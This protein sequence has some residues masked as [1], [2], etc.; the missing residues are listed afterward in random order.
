VSPQ[1]AFAGTKSDASAK[2]IKAIDGMMIKLGSTS[3]R[4]SAAINSIYRSHLDLLVLEEYSAIEGALGTGGLVALPEDPLRFNLRVRVEGPAPIGEKDL[5]NQA[6]YIA[7]R[8]AALGALFDVASR[9]T[10]GPVEVTSL[11]R[12]SEYQHEL[13]KT[14]SNARTSVPTHTMGLAFDIA[15][16][17]TPLRTVYEIRDV[18]ARMQAAGDILVIG[19]RKQLVFHV[20]PHPSRLGYFAEVYARAVNAGLTGASVVP[21]AP[22]AHDTGP[23]RP[24]V[25]ADIVAV[26]PTADYVEEWWAADGA[27]SDMVVSVSPPGALSSTP[28]ASFF[29]RFASRFATVFTNMFRWLRD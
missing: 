9:V 12:H 19:E 15:L 24:T 29:G 1:F 28:T 23:L 20:V 18:L 26:Y 11:V 22:V 17:N 25:K 8:P 14:N 3:S 7:A 21:S 5:D 2:F 13:R 10:S 4:A 6:T 16:V 27:Q